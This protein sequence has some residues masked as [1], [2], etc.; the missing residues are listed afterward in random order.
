MV[1]RYGKLASRFITVT[2]TDSA[3]FLNGLVSNRIGTVDGTIA[4]DS[5]WYVNKSQYEFTEAL[6]YKKL[7]QYSL[8]LTSVG[9]LFLD[10]W[11]YPLNLFSRDGG[12]LIET[13]KYVGPGLYNLFRLHKLASQVEVAWLDDKYASYYVFGDDKNL[14]GGAKQL[15]HGKDGA[16]AQQRLEQFLPGRFRQAQ[17]LV[18]LALDERGAEGVK[19]IAEKDA[20]IED[21][22]H[23]SGPVVEESEEY[24]DT[25]RMYEGI[26]EVKQG[27]LES[28]KYLPL[29]LSYNFMGIKDGSP[30]ISFN[31]GCYVGQ[32]LTHR[33]FF[34]GV[35]RKRLLPVELG[36]AVSELLDR[37]IYYEEEVPE[38]E[39]EGS[40]AAPA[41]AV[42]ASPFGG[43]AR[44]RKKTAGRVVKV[45]GT[46]GLALI[47]IDEYL[48][49][50]R[51]FYVK[52]P[53]KV[54]ITGFVPDWFPE[55]WNENE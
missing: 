38:E 17:K 35:I 26:A 52:A 30:V 37:L 27:E 34:R 21:L 24:L 49:P 5:S 18:A 23:V 32:E 43:A 44:P 22:M 31:K 42:A 25:R 19:V 6:E 2:G 29:E 9:R 41:A 15:R 1:L 39:P 53:G 20:A 8:M 50:N 28:S 4:H 11:V 7:G 14:F 46:L 16:D 33:T 10:I 47:N 54:A 55:D 45:Q 40:E 36:E 48:K 3:K 13:N 51:E 12:Y